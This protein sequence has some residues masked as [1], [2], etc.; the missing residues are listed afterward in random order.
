MA[1]KPDQKLTQ[2][3]FSPDY[4]RHRLADTDALPQMALLGLIAGVASALIIIGFRSLFELPLAHWLPNGTAEGFES[5][6]TL[7]H[8]L[9]PVIGGG[10]I[11]L[12][13]MLF[14]AKARQT[15]VTHVMQRMLNHKGYMPFKNTLVQFFGGALAIITG[16]SGGRE[17]PAVHLGAAISSQLGRFW[18]LP[19]NSIRTLVGCGTAGAIAASFNTPMAG[20]IFAMEVVMLEYTV[21]GFTPIIISAVTATLV[22]N[23]LY[24]AEMA[25]MAPNIAFVSLQEMPLI[26]IYGVI[27][28]ALAALFT[29]TVTV[30]LSVGDKPVMLRM[31]GAGLVTGL[32]ATQVP[33]IMGVGT[34]SILAAIEGQYAIQ[35]LLM[36]ALAKL[37][38]TA[39]SVGLGMPIGLIGPTLLIGASAGGALGLISQDLIAGPIST[40]GFY[41]MLGMAAMMSAVLQAPLAGLIALLELTHNPEVILP[42]MA[43]VVMAN[44]TCR[45]IFKQDSTFIEVLRRQGVTL[46]DNSINQSLTQ[47]GVTSLMDD[48]IAHHADHDMTG[49]S[50]SIKQGK[51][52]LLVY[53]ENEIT[54]VI[55]SQD[56][57]QDQLQDSIQQARS[58]VASEFGFCSSRATLREA[59]DLSQNHDYAYLL[60][61]DLDEQVIGVL[62]TN[63]ITNLMQQG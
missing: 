29:K 60:I 32:L 8:F 43:V 34:D 23:S 15:G 27:F 63:K 41:A 35:L 58:A 44:F 56:L 42:G 20:V 31:L 33:Q 38:A 40:S 13:L 36:L 2:R 9:L 11:G 48:Q 62:P 24:G 7:W 14:K 55:A 50:K 22:H 51:E 30:S 10:L 52:W 12:W 39:V 47:R 26:L 18:Q 17:G 28:G 3:L 4:F 25:F 53:K 19:D 49:V 45:Y 59:W 21:V 61:T 5:L 37:F 1:R 57:A 46:Q 16:Q 54:A 6:P